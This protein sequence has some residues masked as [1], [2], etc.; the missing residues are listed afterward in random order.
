VGDGC[1]EPPISVRFDVASLDVGEVFRSGFEFVSDRSLQRLDGL[2]D[3]EYLWEP[4]PDCWTVRRT[5]DG[6]YRAD[7]A[8]PPRDPAPFTT[9]A[10]RIAHIGDFLSRH[11]LR[12][13]AF[14]GGEVSFAGLSPDTGPAHPHDAVA[15]R[16]Y[17]TAAIDDWKR[18][19]RS[20]DDDHLAELMGC[21]AGQFADDPVASFVLHIHTEFVHHSA[22]VA[23]LRDL[24]RAQA[25]TR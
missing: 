10:W 14:E 11:P 20:V 4:V 21:Q 9:I 1:L 19:L 2:T 16:A 5:D 6:R 25:T 22:E 7:P 8:W 13:V 18:E 3:D 12:A 17:L 15:A 24:Y 23:L